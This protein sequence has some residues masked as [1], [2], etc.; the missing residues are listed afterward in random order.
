MK[1]NVTATVLGR[2]KK[3]QILK[4]FIRPSAASTVSGP[5][6]TISDGAG[7]GNGNCIEFEPGSSVA[8]VSCFEDE[9]DRVTSAGAGWGNGWIKSGGGNGSDRVRSPG[10]GTLMQGGSGSGTFGGGISF[11]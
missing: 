3:Q 4:D 6:I 10:F 1:K 9:F 7:S 2:R 8:P 5:D 11:A